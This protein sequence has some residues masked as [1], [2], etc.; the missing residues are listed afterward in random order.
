M[1]RSI[2]QAALATLVALSAS[3][4]STAQADSA[5]RGAT[6][7]FGGAR[8]IVES[9][10]AQ[11]PAEAGRLQLMRFDIDAGPVEMD[12]TRCTIT[13][14]SVYT[15]LS[16]LVIVCGG[17]THVFSLS[18]LR[19][20]YS[21]S[22]DGKSFLRLTQT[23]LTAF[24]T[25]ATGPA[26]GLGDDDK[27]WRDKR[28]APFYTALSSALDVLKSTGRPLADDAQFAAVVSSY[29][30]SPAKLALPDDAQRYQQ[31][32]EAA[33]DV[34]QHL[35]AAEAYERALE[36]A[37][38][39]PAGYR[40][41][42]LSLADSHQYGPAIADMQRYLALAPDAPDASDEQDRMDRWKAMSAPVKTRDH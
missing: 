31:Q 35:D 28:T 30:A 1:R 42:A 38:W 19:P 17:E 40:G 2:W 8:A 22:N 16:Q 5:P 27:T 26:Y 37:P 25:R 11:F 23:T 15:V 13:K 10:I 20:A 29:R 9:A 39:W 34:G 12:I 4:C 24:G 33:Y 14:I 6:L 3:L 18:A 41:M 21:Y 36:A 32:A 7:S